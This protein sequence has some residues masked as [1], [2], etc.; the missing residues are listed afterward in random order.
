MDL[1]I[2]GIA[3]ETL[4][5]IASRKT[6]DQFFDPPPRTQEEV[7]SYFSDLKNPHSHRIYYLSGENGPGWVDGAALGYVIFGGNHEAPPSRIDENLFD[8]VPELKERF[9]EEARRKG[10]NIPKERIGVYAVNIS[11]I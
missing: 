11:D 10:I 8:Q 9:H 7:D 3:G 4:D 6:L 1:L 2:V 5:D